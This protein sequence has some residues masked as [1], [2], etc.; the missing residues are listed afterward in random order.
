[1]DF[2]H[3]R[4]AF[5]SAMGLNVEHSNLYPL[6]IMWLLSPT[7]VHYVVIISHPCTLCSYYL[8]PL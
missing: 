1:M 8:P 3:L 5:D 2:L 4:P 7:L 6:Y